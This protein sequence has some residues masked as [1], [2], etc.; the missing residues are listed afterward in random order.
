MPLTEVLD[1][2]NDRAIRRIQRSLAD[3]PFTS[4]REQV[5]VVATTIRKD[6]AIDITD[7]ETSNLFGHLWGWAQCMIS[8]AS[9]GSS[10]F[11]ILPPFC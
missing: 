9:P 4:L 7:V 5:Y 2:P 3:T 10:L 11:R 1:H 6:M 8:S